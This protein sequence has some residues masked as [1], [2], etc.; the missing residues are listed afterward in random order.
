M[1]SELTSLHS[2]FLKVGPIIFNE[3]YLVTWATD[4]RREDGTGRIIAG[5]SSLA[6]AGAVVADQSGNILII[7]HLGGL[8]LASLT[9]L[10]TRLTT[11]TVRSMQ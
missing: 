9:K 8:L 2:H 5:E 11:L 6:H 7:A 1:T 4:D 10:K 3:F